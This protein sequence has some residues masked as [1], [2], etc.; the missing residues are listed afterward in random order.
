MIAMF[1]A[2]LAMAPSPQAARDVRVTVTVVDQTGAVIPNAKVTIPPGE[3]VATNEK[4][5]ATLSGLAAGKVS[6][7]AEFPGFETRTLK[8][9]AIKA[10]DNKHVIVLPIQG[11]QDSVTV[12]RDARE[13]A[14]DRK[15]TF[16]SAMTREQ[17]E[18]LSDD[19]DEMAQQLKDIAGSDAVIRVDSFEGGRL[20]PKSAIKAIHI[21]RDAFAAENHYA[22]GLFVDIITQPGVG[23]LRTGMNFRLRDGS[24]SGKPPA[25]TGAGGQ[26]GPERM[27]NYGLNFG[28]SLIKNKASFSLSFNGGT[29]YDTPY[30][31]YYLPNGSLVNELATRRPRDNMFV[32]GLFDYAITRDQT[33]RIRYSHDSFTS[34]N[35]GIGG[36]N[37]QQRAYSSDEKGHYFQIQEAGPL[38]R[39]FFINTRAMI[40]WSDSDN[41]SVFEAETI[42]VLET[43]INGG[44]QRRGGVHSRGINLQSDLDYVRGMNS[45]RA[46]VQLEGSNYHS[47]DWSNYLG[48]Y[49]FESLAAFNAGTPRS[50][51]RR[52]G[53]PNI[54][55]R[56]LQ[57]GLYLQDDIRV[58]KNLTLSPGIRYEAQTH[59]DDY[60]NW[61]PRFGATWSPG[62][63]G[64]MTIRGSAGIFYDWLSTSVYEQT[65]RVDGEHQREINVPFP[66][67]PVDPT[68]VGTTLPT[69]KYLLGDNLAMQ[70]NF[71]VSAGI[72]R[73]ITKMLRVNALYAYTR[74]TNLMRGLTLNNPIDGT[75]PDPNYSNVVEVIGDAWSQANSLNVGA[76]LNF[77]VANPSGGPMMMGPGVM[78]MT[79]GGAPTPP[80]QKRFNWRRMSI[81]TNMYFGRSYNNTDGAF[82]L[83]ATGNF[84]DDWGPAAFD[85]RNRFNVSWSSQ[86]IRNLNMNLNLNASTSQPYT[87]RAGYDLNNDL[88]FTDRPEGV[89]RNTERAS[90]QWTTNGN[91]SYGWSFGKAVERAG[92]ITLRGDAGGIS[93][94]QA[95]ATTQ[96]RYRLSLNVNVQNMFNHHNPAGF[97]F[98]QTSKSYGQPTSFTGT[99]K[100]DIGLSLSF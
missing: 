56:N 37:V 66:T 6:I 83:P 35:I 70:R 88:A 89:G 62:K 60:N 40:N 86:Q 94:S 39:R 29:S 21:T 2:L 48:T 61:G 78:I 36:Y 76:S 47:D 46:G 22:G 87:I 80:G 4:G 31:Y 95:A 14:S 17:I 16:G 65:L 33:L 58:R 72:D 27:Q 3:A 12:S 9:I 19:P 71:R 28:G 99:R 8:D 68:A 69:N 50:Y 49:T 85:I 52:I 59:L 7:T 13:T 38:G 25:A 64:T 93:A 1:L 92:G 44:Q 34:K 98:V 81:F 77:N 100:V 32:Y 26:K 11:L 53:D 54:K 90:G 41:R 30:Y 57:A 15:A 79:A 55:Y 23:P 84:Q 67:Y 96:G 18:A 82:S 91:F 43:F 74:G 75:R 24:L 97:S 42:N 5:I 10:G 20:P 51:T 63:A 45:W 73:G